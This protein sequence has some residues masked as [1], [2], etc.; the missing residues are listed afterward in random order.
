MA[1]ETT[2]FSET[3]GE[4]LERVY[5]E[6]DGIIGGCEDGGELATTLTRALGL[7]SV[8]IDDEDKEP[9]P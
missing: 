9:L 5:D 7:I 3:R 8:A 4:V 2:S 1:T 6:I